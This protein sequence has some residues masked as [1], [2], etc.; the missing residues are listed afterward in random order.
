MRQSG[1]SGGPAG[2]LQWG[3]NFIVAEMYIL[4]SDRTAASSLQWGRNFIGA[5]ILRWLR[6]ALLPCRRFNGAATLSLRKLSVEEFDGIP[7]IGF[8]GAATLSLRKFEINAIGWGHHYRASMGPQ[9]YRCGNTC[10]TYMP[11]RT[12]SCFNGAATLSLRKWG[13]LALLPVCQQPASMG[14]QLYR[15]GNRLGSERATLIDIVLQWGRNFI[16]AE[17]IM[18]RFSLCRMNVLQW[19]R[20]FIVAEILSM[21][22]RFGPVAVSLQ[23]RPQL[24]RCGNLPRTWR[25]RWRCSSFNGAATLSLRKL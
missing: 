22:V 24:Y 2:G 4:P 17:M 13:R 8:N 25:S 3:R 15:C 12:L 21:V 23:W 6:S 16:V 18:G 10:Q 9:L 5:E 1:C 14:P 20:N 19:G 11:G 7:D